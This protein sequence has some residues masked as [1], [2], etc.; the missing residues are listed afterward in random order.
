M[1]L[2]IFDVIIFSVLFFASLVFTRGSSYL[3]P[4]YY[5]LWLMLIV[6]RSFTY[7][8]YKKN[9]LSFLSLKSGL[10]LI[11]W[12]NSVIVFTTIFILSITQFSQIPR[13]FAI[14]FLLYP[15]IIDIIM[16][17]V[18]SHG[19]TGDDKLTQLGL[20]EA[21][22]SITPIIFFSWLV[23]M[24]M[25]YH[26]TILIKYHSVNYNNY[27]LY[28]FFLIFPA[29]LLSALFTQKYLDKNNHSIYL[30][31][32]QHLKS[33]IILVTIL[34][35]PHFFFRMENLSRYMLFGT[36]IFSSLFD[37]F[38][39]T[40]KYL[41]KRSMQEHLQ[42]I[43]DITD[44]H[45]EVIQQPLK[46]DHPLTQALLSEEQKPEFIS[47]ISA[48]IPFDLEEF[49]NH[50]ANQKK[51]DRS[52]I[53]L[54]STT[55]TETI[56]I[57]N[58]NSVLVN[59]HIC[60]DQRRLNK[61]LIACHRSLDAGGLMVGY[62]EPLEIVNENLRKKLPRILFLIISPFHFIFHRIFPKLKFVNYIYFLITRG[63]NRIISK[64]EMFGRLSYCGFD[65][66]SEVPLGGMMAFIAQKTKT[67]SSELKPSFKAIVGLKRVGFHGDTIDIYKV[68]TMHP[69]SEFLQKYVYDS[70]SL[71]NSG[72][73]RNDFRL[74]A[75]GKVFRKMW[76]DELPQLY[77]WVRG[78]VKI[79]GV[80]ALSYHYY[81]LYPDHI[82]QL[83]IKSKPG[84]I[85]P[86]YVDLPKNFD[87]IIASEEKYL[88]SYF[89]KPI[90]TDIVYFF[91]AL[92]NI[93]LRGSRSQ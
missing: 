8:Y 12:S 5:K 36:A 49:L 38:L 44:E 2:F 86:Y 66:I 27:T 15:M 34:A 18:R 92:K 13:S 89:K 4:L 9:S 35:I 91:L 51:L 33:S 78:D 87:E 76:I 81:S 43:D 11:A 20:S 62:F 55:S 6:I 1:K 26:I 93:I 28:I 70:Q 29:W 17:S 64:A 30:I 67:V 48:N 77:N 16:V 68:R 41:H 75:W 83:R 50:I 37:F 21:K 46:L 10:F 3:T 31:I 59:F 61:Y 72:K 32:G 40:S 71:D 53:S 47:L 25:A 14:Q 39:S 22:T 54:L 19:K 52:S 24:F 74:T 90:Y 88:N 73:F 82:K 56:L 58:K 57:Q 79:V 45:G 7:F 63:K 42:S 80:R 60:N 65:I 84:L 23:N 85:P 69:Y